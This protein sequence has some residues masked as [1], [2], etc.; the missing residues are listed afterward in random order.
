MNSSDDDFITVSKMDAVR[1][2]LNT[3]IELWFG[4]GDPVSIHTLAS[5]AHDILHQLFRRS[6]LKG[7]LFGT[8]KICDRDRQQWVAAITCHYNFFKHGRKDISAK[9]NFR[10]AVNEFLIFFQITALIRMSE[11]LSYQERAFFYWFLT[12]RP[13]LLNEG[14]AYLILR[15]T[16]SRTH[17]AV[18]RSVTL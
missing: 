17:F 14:S 3:A 4:D 10:P 16:E 6:G 12:N 9:A 18:S 8:T 11:N 2:Q 7:L 5:A 13:E 15:S 1:R